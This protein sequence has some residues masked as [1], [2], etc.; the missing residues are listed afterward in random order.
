MSHICSKSDDESTNASDANGENAS[1]CGGTIH[2]E[3]L[4][5]E[6]H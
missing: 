3:R 4:K 5:R 2:N 1:A 6:K